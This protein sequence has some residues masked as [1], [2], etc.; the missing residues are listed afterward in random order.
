[1]EKALSHDSRKRLKGRKLVSWSNPLTMI[2]GGTAHDDEITTCVEVPLDTSN[3]ALAP[4]V[5]LATQRLFALFDGYRMPMHVVEEY[6][7][8]LIERTLVYG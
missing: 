6:V 5:E 1:M 7:R 3:T 4:F 8:R 2:E